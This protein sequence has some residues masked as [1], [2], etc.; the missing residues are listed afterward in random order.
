VWGLIGQI[1]IAWAFGFSLTVR[2]HNCRTLVQN[3]I[4][5]KIHSSPQFFSDY[6]ESKM[7]WV[8]IRLQSRSTDDWTV[9]L[10]SFFSS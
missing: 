9:V 10:Q 5:S 4:S 2:G 6:L 8:W 3:L 7:T 1:K